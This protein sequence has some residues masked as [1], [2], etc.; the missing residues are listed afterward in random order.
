[1]KTP[2]DKVK[3]SDIELVQ[4]KGTKGS[5]GS[6]GGYYW[7]V[8]CKDKRVGR[9]YINLVT[10]ES[11]KEYASITVELNQDSRGRGIGAICFRRACEL[12]GYNKVYAE[13]RKS[14]I[15]SQKAAA[16]AGFSPAKGYK[17]PQLLMVWSGKKQ[18][19]TEKDE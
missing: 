11:G 18:R 14:N 6:A 5:G 12:S 15:A 7:H 4:G 3:E 9:V 10:H 16:R 8:Y 13:M 1:M 19:S 2:T 17:G